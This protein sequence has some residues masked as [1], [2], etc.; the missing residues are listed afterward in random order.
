MDIDELADRLVAGVRGRSPL[1]DAETSKVVDALAKLADE[2]VREQ[3]ANTVRLDHLTT[4]IH[5][6]TTHIAKLDEW[7]GD[8]P[9]KVAD[10]I[11]ATVEARV[12]GPIAGALSRQAPAIL[13][14]LQ[15]SKLVDIVSRSVREAQ[16]PLLREILAGGRA[17]LPW[18][19]FMSLLIPLLLILGYLYLP[20]DDATIQQE[21]THAREELVRGQEDIIDIVQQAGGGEANDRLSGIEAAIKNI[22]DEAMVHAQNNVRLEEEVK[23][24]RAGMSTQDKALEEYKAVVVKQDGRLHQYE[25]RLT[26]LGVSPSSLGD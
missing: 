3:N 9:D 21:L 24:L 25:R 11:G 14:E 7:R 26:Q 6:A 2:L 10:E 13:S 1:L 18:W 8:L 12:V 23:T 22:R 4:E 15:D 19:T 5:N 20:S 17:G 16:R